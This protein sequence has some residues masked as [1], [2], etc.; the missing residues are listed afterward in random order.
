MIKTLLNYGGDAKSSQLSMAMFYKETPVK[1][2]VLNPVAE[3]VDA[4]MGLKVRYAF[5]KDSNAVDM[6]SA[7]HSNIVL[8]PALSRIH[9]TCW[10]FVVWYTVTNIFALFLIIRALDL[11]CI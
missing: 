3:D 9:E 10:C 1:M 8:D 5:T 7:I 11:K 6:V 4:N 2:D